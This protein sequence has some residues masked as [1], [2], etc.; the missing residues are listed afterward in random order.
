MATVKRGVKGLRGVKVQFYIFFFVIDL[1]FDN[2]IV[3][4][5]TKCHRIEIKV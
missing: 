3:Y 5:Q 4:S 1:L 2:Y